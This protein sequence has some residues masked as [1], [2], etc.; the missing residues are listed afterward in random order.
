VASCEAVKRELEPLASGT[1]I[2]INLPFGRR[3]KQESIMLDRIW[4]LICSVLL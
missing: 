2:V 3:L 4:L 1:K